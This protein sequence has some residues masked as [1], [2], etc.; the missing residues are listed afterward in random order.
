MW[1]DSTS[2]NATNLSLRASQSDLCACECKRLI[3]YARNDG[4]KPLSGNKIIGPAVIEKVN[5]SIFVG[6]SWG[7]LVDEFGSFSR[8]FCNKNLFVLIHIIKTCV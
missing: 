4:D 3:R 5:T 2:D 8:W 6:E 7:C 1:R